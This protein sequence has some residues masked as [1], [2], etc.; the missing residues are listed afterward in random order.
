MNKSTLLAVS[1]LL[2]L[3][4]L[5]A[6]AADGVPHD[7]ERV[8]GHHPIDFDADAWA[9]PTGGASNVHNASTTTTTATPGAMTYHGGNIMTQVHAR[10]YFIGPKWAGV[11]F[12]K[13]KITG[14]DAFFEGYSGSTYAKSATEYTGAN[15]VPA[16]TLSYQ[17]HVVDTATELDPTAGLLPLVQYVCKAV[18]SGTFSADT[19]GNQ[20]VYLF[21]DLTRPANGPY[22][23]FHSEASCGGVLVPYAFVYNDDTDT[24]CMVHDTTT[25]HSSPLAGIANSTAHETNEMRSDPGLNAW[26]DSAG[27]ENGDK[28]GWNFTAN[29]VLF[30]NGSKWRIQSEWSNNAF[31][32]GTGVAN[33]SGQKGCIN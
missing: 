8:H 7:Q 31:N 13:D 24:G 2:A 6:H 11:A 9:N 22:C 15:G 14:M 21:S 19:S 1:V 27:N 23:A 25:G 28:C 3:G 10:A 12:Q 4:S 5:G 33:A 18:Q 16:P 30:S 26:Y 32:A 29:Y 20:A 17:G